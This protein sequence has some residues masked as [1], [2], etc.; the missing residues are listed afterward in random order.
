MTK[1]TV[2]KSFV[3]LVACVSS[4]IYLGSPSSATS[5]Q[6]PEVPRI[7]DAGPAASFANVV[8]GQWIKLGGFTDAANNTWT[9]IATKTDSDNV[10]VEGMDTAGP[11]TTESGRSDFRRCR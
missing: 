4:V 5:P 10:T 7:V 1:Q 2:L 3:F 9:R 11:F 8:V 6:S